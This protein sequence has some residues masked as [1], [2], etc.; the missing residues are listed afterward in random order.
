MFDGDE[1]GQKAAKALKPL[2]ED[3][4]FIVEIIDLPD[5]TDPGELDQTDVD[6]TAEYI[7]K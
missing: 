4:E 5:G 6:A 7:S 1:A 3:C 2:I